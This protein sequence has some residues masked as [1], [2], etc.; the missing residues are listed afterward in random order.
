MGT[1]KRI[2][3]RQSIPPQEFFALSVD[4]YHQMI[5]A[6]VFADDDR[7]ELLEGHLVKKMSKSP[8]HAAVVMRMLSRLSQGC[9]PGFVVRVEQP[10]TLVDTLA[11][12]EPEPD[13]SVARG[14]D[15]DFDR[16]HPSA[17]DV[18]LVVEVASSSAELDRTVK[19][20]IYA[21]A[22]IASYVILILESKTAEVYTKPQDGTYA[23]KTVLSGR[24]SLPVVL[25][26]KKVGSVKLSDV[27]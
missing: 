12:S 9:G 5:T 8:I 11:D 14:S 6:G 21:R 18:E 19:L 1:M 15:R 27:F 2:V 25:G 26:G 10:I 16:R 24:Q 17:D 4:Q 3:E 7:V 22:G 20:S 13:V 23:K